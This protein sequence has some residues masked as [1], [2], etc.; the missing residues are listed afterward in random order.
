MK[1]FQEKNKNRHKKRSKLLLLLMFVMVIFLARGS[2]STYFKE[3]D[4]RV[5][6]QRVLAEKQE[7]EGRYNIISEQSDALKSDIGIET[8]IRNKFDVV[9]RGEGVIVVV[10]KDAPVIEADKRG[11]LRR[12]WDS[13]RGVFGSDIEADG[14]AAASSTQAD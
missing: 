2:M 12:F 4:S 5:E 1:E 7:L 8:E 13:V 6:V 9:K 3:R 11:V 10:E 14:A